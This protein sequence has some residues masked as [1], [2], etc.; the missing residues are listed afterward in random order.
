MVIENLGAL[1][2]IMLK[3]IEK[4]R[5]GIQ[6]RIR[7]VEWVVGEKIIPLSYIAR[8]DNNITASKSN[9]LYNKILNI[10]VSKP[11]KKEIEAISKDFR[12]ALMRAW[13]DRGLS[14][15]WEYGII[16]DHL[17]YA[18]T[19][20][21]DIEWRVNEGFVI[22]TKGWDRSGNSPKNEV[23]VNVPI[24]LETDNELRRLKRRK[25]A[26]LRS[27]LKVGLQDYYKLEEQFLAAV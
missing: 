4:F 6:T 3:K 14:E 20:P 11:L 8:E 27:F 25:S 22:L 5:G 12:F 15:W 19:A 2:E 13:I 10:S 17:P 16:E 26:L 18:T 23:A 7:D 1:S 21:R 9:I 24:T